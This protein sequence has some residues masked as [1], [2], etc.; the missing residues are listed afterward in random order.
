MCVCWEPSS[1]SLIGYNTLLR[2]IQD[3]AVV[4]HH[5]IS[6]TAVPTTGSGPLVL[7]RD[8]FEEESS[9]YRCSFPQVASWWSWWKGT[10][11][12]RRQRGHLAIIPSSP[13][14]QALWQNYNPQNR[15]VRVCMRVGVSSCVCLAGL[16]RMFRYCCWCVL[17]AFEWHLVRVLLSLQEAAAHCINL[18]LITSGARY[19]GDYHR[20]V[21][22]RATERRAATWTERQN[23]C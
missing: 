12:S 7:I 15:R 19:C 13:A 21:C 20:D 1:K 14:T 5:L 8:L 9:V 10:N 18:Q 22:L 11:T 16:V 4:P 3:A 23:Y 2:A 17:I 6:F